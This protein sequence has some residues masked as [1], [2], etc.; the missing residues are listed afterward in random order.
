MRI[1]IDATCWMNR[2][3]YGRFTRE[4]LPA[5]AALAPDD[6]LICFVTQEEVAAFDLAHPNVETRAV[7]LS[8]SPTAAASARGHRAVG[9]ML[10]L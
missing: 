3:G 4:L 8:A 9:D 1:G 5:V 6:T 10:K 7:N 2:R